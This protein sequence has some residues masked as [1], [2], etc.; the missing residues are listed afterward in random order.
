LFRG[1]ADI[2]KPVTHSNRQR[3]KLSQVLQSIAELEE[4]HQPQPRD[5][6]DRNPAM[7]EF[8]NS[9]EL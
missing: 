8:L 9:W 6:L 7:E 5:S 4:R 2:A 3:P 1:T